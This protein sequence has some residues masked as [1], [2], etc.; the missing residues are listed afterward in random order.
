[1]VCVIYLIFFI[2]IVT[3]IKQTLLMRTNNAHK[4]IQY[5]QNILA[6]HL[7][8]L[9]LLNILALHLK[10]LYIHQNTQHVQ[11]MAPEYPSIQNTQFVK[12]IPTGSVPNHGLEPHQKHGYAYSQHGYEQLHE[13]GYSQHGYAYLQHEYGYEQ[14]TQSQQ[15]TPPQ[16]TPPQQTPQQQTHDGN[17]KLAQI[18][19]NKETP[20]S[21]IDENNN[22]YGHPPPPL[23]NNVYAYP[24]PSN[25]Q[26]AYPPPSNNNVY[27]HPPPPFNNQYAYPPPPTP[28]KYRPPPPTPN[29]YHPPPPFNNHPYPQYGHPP[30]PNDYNPPTID[31]PPLKFD[32]YY[33]LCKSFTE[34]KD[35][36]YQHGCIFRHYDFIERRNERTM[37]YPNCPIPERKQFPKKDGTNKIIQWIAANYPWVAEEYPDCVINEKNYNNNNNN[38]NNN[39]EPEEVPSNNYNNYNYNNN[40][41]EMV[42]YANNTPYEPA[43]F[44]KQDPIGHVLQQIHN[45]QY[46]PCHLISIFGG[47][48]YDSYQKQKHW[49]A[50]QMLLHEIYDI[51]PEFLRCIYLHNQ[52][53]LDSQFK[54]NNEL[55]RTHSKFIQQNATRVWKE[56]QTK[57][58]QETRWKSGTQQET[59]TLI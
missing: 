6:L 39:N 23:N 4:K 37:W 33:A 40:E 24:P 41:P 3:P 52:H 59:N 51:H 36:Y 38:N 30:P 35:C 20:P 5:V 10:I 19:E 21:K 32:D 47:N 26:S 49:E 15:Q 31:T 2:Q 11:N 12:N 22:V 9:H 17:N 1:M 56:L 42:S 25:N 7:K 28:N 34:G 27:G 50:A 53:V 29:K 16:Q 54:I 58:Q 46:D 43:N 48:P 57:I 44:Y 45:G 8:I 14:Q 18:D 55:I 13:Y